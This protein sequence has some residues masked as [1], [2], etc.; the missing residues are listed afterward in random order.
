MLNSDDI[1]FYHKILWVEYICGGSG[2]SLGD[3]FTDKKDREPEWVD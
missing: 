2:D 1:M 3:I